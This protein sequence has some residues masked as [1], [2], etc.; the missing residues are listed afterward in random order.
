MLKKIYTYVEIKL[1]LWKENVY[2][3]AELCFLS[4]TFA[5]RRIPNWYSFSL[6]ICSAGEKFTHAPLKLKCQFMTDNFI[7]SELGCNIGNLEK[8]G[9]QKHTETSMEWTKDTNVIF[10]NSP[11]LWSVK[12]LCSMLKIQ[13]SNQFKWTPPILIRKLAKYLVKISQWLEKPCSF[14]ATC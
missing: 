9:G 10:Q 2:F 1:F 5:E 14:S 4:M 7:S 8:G 11:D 13:E 3:S 12:Y 6:I